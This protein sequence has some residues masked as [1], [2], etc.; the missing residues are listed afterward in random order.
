VIESLHQQYP[1]V[2]VTD[3]DGTCGDSIFQHNPR[4]TRLD[5]WDDE[6][7]INYRVED[8]D[9]GN[10]FCQAMCNHVSKVLK[11]ENGLMNVCR[12]PMIYLTEDE[13]KNSY[14]L[15][16]HFVVGNFGYKK[17][18]DIKNKGTSYIWKKV[19]D[20]CNSVGVTVIQVGEKNPD[21]VHPKIE[22][23]I[24][25]I[26]KTTMRDL[27]VI[28]SKAI[29]TVGPISLLT[30]VAASH[31]V[32]SITLSS[33]EALDF[34]GYRSTIWLHTYG[35]LPCHNGKNGQSGC[36]R[37]HLEKFITDKNGNF[38]LDKDGNKK[39]T[40]DSCAL[41]V[42]TP[43]GDELVP[44]CSALIGPDTIIQHLKVIFKAKGII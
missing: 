24:D 38:I 34:A 26:G 22:G 25:A 8:T 1:G 44:K 7:Y 16:E 4:I 3:F 17:D 14:N 13:N 19:T 30:H 15:P 23:A 11:L 31:D 29:C 28:T 32:P 37:N 36:W 41:P 39:K 12:K 5:K 35:L 9:T 10:S 6:V 33:R 43:N 27:L 20:Y 21:H 18:C 42:L 40:S 2:F